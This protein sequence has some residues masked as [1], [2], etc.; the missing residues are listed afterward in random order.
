MTLTIADNDITRIVNA[1]SSIGSVQTV[2]PVG[3]LPAATGS[4][5]ATYIKAALTTMIDTLVTDHEAKRGAAG[6]VAPA[7]T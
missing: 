5:A 4:A 1:L 6:G 3:V 2:A 7:I